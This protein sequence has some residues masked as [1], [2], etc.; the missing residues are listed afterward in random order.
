MSLLGQCSRALMLSPKLWSMEVLILNTTN[1]PTSQQTNK[2]ANKQTNKQTNHNQPTNKPT[3]QQ[4]NKQTNKPTNQQTNKQDD[5]RKQTEIKQNKAKQN[6]AK[7]DKTKQRKANKRT[8]R[9]TDKQTNKQRT[10]KPR[11]NEP[12]HQHNN[13]QTNPQTNDNQP[14]KH[15]NQLASLRKRVLFYFQNPLTKGPTKLTRPGFISPLH[16][17]ERR[18]PTTGALDHG[19]GREA[20]LYEGAQAAR[21]LLLGRCQERGLRKFPWVIG[22]VPFDQPRNLPPK[23]SPIKLGALEAHRASK[24]CLSCPTSSETDC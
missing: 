10:K 14:N 3:N 23:L 20:I 18:R 24:R 2:Q 21:M 15:H 22:L 12:T 1:Q 17:D 9:Q 8:N 4:T 7:Q 5:K 6:K 16:F 19:R 11:T 13:K